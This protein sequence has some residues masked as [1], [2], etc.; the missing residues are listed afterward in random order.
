MKYFVSVLFL[1]LSIGFN[2]QKKHMLGSIFEEIDT[3]AHPFKEF[4]EL[5]SPLPIRHDLS[6]LLPEVGYQDD[7]GS[8]VAWSS[9]YNA[10]TIVKRIEE[11]NMYYPAFSH[12]RF[13]SKLKKQY[14]REYHRTGK[15]YYL[16]LSEC[17][18]G[19][20]RSD[21]ADRL[22]QYGAPHLGDHDVNTCTDENIDKVYPD[23]LYGWDYVRLDVDL[24]KQAL[25]ENSPL[26]FGIPSTAGNCWKQDRSFDDGVW[27]GNASGSRRGGHAMCIVGYDDQ[28]GENGAFKVVN[29]WDTDWGIAGFF[30]IQYKDVE[31]F[32]SA[33]QYELNPYKNQKLPKIK[34]NVQTIGELPK[35]QKNRSH[36]H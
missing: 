2:A 34:A 9:V 32:N 22:Q 28:K 23:R 5:R 7:L 16:D 10:F 15:G 13:H 4:P 30:W 21:A 18:E 11:N 14:N 26:V 8:C 33:I 19:S 12:I 6:Y 3:V 25:Y 31:K 27:D 1:S 36:I 24:M 29:S 17:D 20:L 35:F